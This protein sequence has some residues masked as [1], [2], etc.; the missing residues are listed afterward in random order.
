MGS[1]ST[2]RKIFIATQCDA[3]AVAKIRA[4]NAALA[5]ELATVESAGTDI[6]SATVNG[7]SYAGTTSLT[8]LARFSMLSDVC[9]MY[10]ANAAISS[11]TT[12]VFPGPNTNGYR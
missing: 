6:T 7:Q 3:A 9:A 4:E 1:F 10:D 2:A 11:R 5:L 12:P 8:K